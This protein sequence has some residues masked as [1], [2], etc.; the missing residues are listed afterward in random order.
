MLTPRISFQGLASSIQFEIWG[1]Y[2]L[3]MFPKMAP[4]SLKPQARPDMNLQNSLN[5]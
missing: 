5:K 4:S 2:A 1:D 3:D